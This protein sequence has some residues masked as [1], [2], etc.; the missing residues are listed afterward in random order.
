MSDIA[1]PAIL[2]EDLGK[3]FGPVAAVDGLNLNVAPGEI[4]GLIGP[5][6]AGKT[7]TIRLLSSV[8]MPT[9]GRALVAGHDTVRA[10]EAIRRAVGYMPQRFTLYGDLTVR[11]NLDFFAD[12]FAVRGAERRRRITQAL[13]FSRLGEF[14]QRRA[15]NLSGGMQKKLALASVLLHR[16]ALLFLDEPTTGVDPISRR[17]FW[18]LLTDLHL[19]GFTLFVSTPYMDEAERCSRVGLMYEGRL[20]VC[21]DPARVPDL[22]PGDWLEVRTPA[23]LEAQAALKTLPGVLQV[24]VYGDLLHVAVDAAATRGPEIATTLAG[25]GVPV[26]GL[27]PDRPRLEEAFIALIEARER[28]RA[29]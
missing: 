4:F 19:Q 27:R 18:D 2:A 7:T 24:Q 8:L 15:A 22:V 23:L 16:P 9:R 17:E 5:D 28:A 25:R 3:S 6:G 13:E 21:D 20:M 10:S 26:T 11:E 29:Q 12:V 14:Q 1:I